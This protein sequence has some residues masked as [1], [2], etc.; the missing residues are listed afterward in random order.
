M[1][2]HYTD[3][4]IKSHHT[5]GMDVKAKHFI[6]YDSVEDLLI[7]LSKLR[8]EGSET[9]WMHI[10]SGSNLLFLALEYEGTILHSNIKD[11]SIVDENESNIFLRVGSGV[12]WDELVEYVVAQGWGGMENLSL[13]P[14]EVGSSAVQN[15]GAYGVEVKDLIVSVEAID[16]SLLTKRTFSVEECKY[17]YRQSVFKNELKGKFVVTHVTYRLEKNP[18]FN[19]EY[20]NIQKEIDVIGRGTSL[21]SIR[22]AIINIRNAKLPDPKVLGN[23][24]SFF[25]NPIVP[26]EIYEKINKNYPQMPYYKV[27]DNFIKIPAG[28]MIEQCGWKGRS[29]GRAAVH[30]KQALVLVNLGG[31]TGEEMVTL[32]KAVQEDVFRKF[33]VTIHPEVNL[34]R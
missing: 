25:M 16:V 21:D 20:G 24:G 7:V 2:K 26:R 32:C 30:D 8:N 29:L 4:S 15:I 1:I 10:G 27:D 9:T 33:G 5:F 14:G 11:Y 34:I 31:A 23:A 19:L 3:Y 12:V 17:A 6:E 22:Q 13:I 18:R 28:W